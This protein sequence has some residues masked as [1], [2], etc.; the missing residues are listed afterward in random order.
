MK[1]FLFLLNICYIIWNRIQHGIDWKTAIETCYGLDLMEDN[2]QECKERICKLFYEMGMSFTKEQCI[3][4]NE[5]LNKNI[6]AHD[7][8]KWNFEEWRPMTDEEIKKYK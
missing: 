6:V 4:I 8:F 3:E 5:I 7:F 1:I 2:I